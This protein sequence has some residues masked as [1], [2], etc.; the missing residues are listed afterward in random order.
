MVDGQ[1][2]SHEPVANIEACAR[3]DCDGPAIFVYIARRAGNGLALDVFG[4]RI[5]GDLATA[6]VPP[7]FVKTQLL[8][9]WRISPEQA[10]TVAMYLDGVAID[11]R[12]TAR[13]ISAGCEGGE[14]HEESKDQ[15]S[16][17]T[18][19]PISGLFQD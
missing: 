14:R 5:R 12:C 4:K 16:N 8:R 6:V 9:F 10:D 13:Q 19:Q 7:F 17:S 3:T 11:D 18:H 1:T 2:P 15:E